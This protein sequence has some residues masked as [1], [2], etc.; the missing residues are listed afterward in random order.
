MNGYYNKTKL[1]HLKFWHMQFL[2]DL[3]NKGYVYVQNNTKSKRIT[4]SRLQRIE[5][6][7]NI[8]RLFDRHPACPDYTLTATGS[9]IINCLEEIVTLRSKLDTLVKKHQR[10]GIKRRVSKEKSDV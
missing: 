7:L 4:Q 6:D 1:D 5:Q 2:I 10:L 8:N 9:A 3:K